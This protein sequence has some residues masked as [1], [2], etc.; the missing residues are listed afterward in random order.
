MTLKDF[1]QLVYMKSEIAM[2]TRRL[3]KTKGDKFV[4][5]YA[6]DY[7]SGYERIIT[8]QGY[9]ITDTKKTG[10]IYALLE[11]RKHELEKQLLMAEQYIASI[12]DSK[13]RTILTLR[14]I[15][16]QEWD[17]VAYNM[18]KKMTGDSARKCISRFFEKINPD[19]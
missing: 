13:I 10:G 4:G 6:K 17:E 2:L 1:E 16:G 18:Y 7:S 8:I 9:T 19:F 14:F 11:I 15:E 3:E 5:D 12:P